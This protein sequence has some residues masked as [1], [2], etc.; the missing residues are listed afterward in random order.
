MILAALTLTLAAAPSDFERGVEA[1]RA[2]RYA[3]ARDAWCA[4]LSQEL[5]E[6]GRAR[7]FFDLGNAH[8]R[9]GES[10]RAI[11]CYTAAVRLDPR[12]A[13]AW[14][15]LEFARA[16]AG[17]PPADSGDLGATL[18]RLGTSLR[19]SER[20]GLL[21]F[22]LLAWCVVLA[23]EARFGGRPLRATLLAATLLAALAAAPWIHGLLAGEPVPSAFAVAGVPLRAE[24]QEARAAV[25][26]LAVL[27][28]VRRIDELPGWTR[29][30]RA[31]GERGWVRADALFDVA[32]P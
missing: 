13:D 27:E 6:P 30:E 9:L 10:L 20:R 16:K 23:L 17:L 14:E 3:E 25:G 7:V 29:I 2:G 15:N 21:F 32:K 26:E 18:R 19:A 8:W 11:A 4:T 12:Q 22:A 28:E 24:P 1:Y 5:D 31:D